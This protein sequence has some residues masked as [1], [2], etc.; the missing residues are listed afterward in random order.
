MNYIFMHLVSDSI[1]LQNKIFK[2][3]AKTVHSKQNKL[4]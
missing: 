1:Q 4:N 3:K 2:I